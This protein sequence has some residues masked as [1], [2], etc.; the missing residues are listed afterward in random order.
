MS[1]DAAVDLPLLIQRAQQGN[2]DAQDTLIRLYQKRIAAFVYA[3]S[4]RSE[5]VEDLAQVVFLKVILALPKLKEIDRF[6]PWLFRLARNVYLDH[7]RRERLRNFFIPATELHDQVPAPVQ[8]PSSRLE[9]LSCALQALPPNQRELLVLLQEREWSYEELASMTGSTVG[10]VKSR[11]F[12]AR[13]ELKRLL[14][15]ES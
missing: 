3:M 9:D 7:Y 10:A 13:T 4:S 12:R 5:L 11:L 14:P 8:R 15:N 2:M 6:E 1:S